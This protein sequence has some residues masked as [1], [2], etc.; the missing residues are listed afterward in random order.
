MSELVK[1][2]LCYFIILPSLIFASTGCCKIMKIKNG[3]LMFY[4]ITQV[5]YY[6]LLQLTAPSYI[7]VFTH[8]CIACLWYHILLHTKGFFGHS[9][10]Q[11]AYLLMLNFISGCKKYCSFIIFGSS[12]LYHPKFFQ[13]CVGPGCSNNSY[14]FLSQED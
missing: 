11:H 5:L 8:H 9:K 13:S 12:F 2:I 14:I 6:D 1:F 10:F 4:F 3:W 7:I